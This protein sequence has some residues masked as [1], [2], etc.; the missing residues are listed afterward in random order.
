MPT[1][2]DWATKTFTVYQSDMTNLGGGIYELDVAALRL[3]LHALQAS[4]V[5][6]TFPEI[7]QH[8]PEFTVGGT[9]YVRA[10]AI[11]N[12]YTMTISPASAYQVSCKGA[13]HNLGDVYNN[14]TGPTLLPN[15]SAGLVNNPAA[16]AVASEVWES[17]RAAHTTA[18]TMGE[19]L[20]RRQ[21]SA[22]EDDGPIQVVREID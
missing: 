14:T 19:K 6:I 18:G 7:F 3:E 4:P 21:V 20:G 2:M 9:T 8:N 12:G 13:N 11:I 17:T 16:S 1:T 22:I 5:G 10:Y 15:N